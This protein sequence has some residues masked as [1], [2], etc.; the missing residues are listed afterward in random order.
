MYIPP[1]T[2]SLVSLAEKSF[3]DSDYL[4]CIST[5]YIDGYGWYDTDRVSSCKINVNT[6]VAITLCP[7]HLSKMELGTY[8]GWCRPRYYD[9]RQ[10]WLQ[11]HQ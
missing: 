10:S 3:P 4:K 8:I 11:R 2:L 6:I 1:S 7:A 5:G 9:F